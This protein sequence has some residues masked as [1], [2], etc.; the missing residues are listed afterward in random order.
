MAQFTLESRD[1]I[2]CLASLSKRLAD[3]IGWV[4]ENPRKIEIEIPDHL[5]HYGTNARR[6]E[7][8]CEVPP[9]MLNCIARG[10]GEE[11][12]EAEILLGIL[13]TKAKGRRRSKT[14]RQK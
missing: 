8:E 11:R 9:W 7:T 1:I 2:R 6:S 14:K 12:A 4:G 3:A 5:Y 13:T 10:L